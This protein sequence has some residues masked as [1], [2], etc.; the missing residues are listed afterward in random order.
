MFSLVVCKYIAESSYEDNSYESKK[1]IEVNT[2][3]LMKV[4]SKSNKAL[5]EITDTQQ[6]PVTFQ[7]QDYGPLTDNE[8]FQPI[9][10]VETGPNLEREIHFQPFTEGK[11]GYRAK[12]LQF[13]GKDKGKSNILKKISGADLRKLREYLFKHKLYQNSEN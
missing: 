11:P 8:S 2:E 13:K 10:E 3:K 9:S 7:Q 4:E 1:S 5:E 12:S 6:N